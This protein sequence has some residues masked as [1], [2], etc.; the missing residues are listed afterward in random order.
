ML[1]MTVLLP[2]PW[3]PTSFNFSSLN[4]PVVIKPQDFNT[5]SAN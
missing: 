1:I 2:K 5:T 4:V 3:Q